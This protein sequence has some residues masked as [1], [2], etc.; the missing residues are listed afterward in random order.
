MLT[1]EFLKVHPLDSARILENL[2]ISDITS[3]L[4]LAPSEIAA[5]VISLMDSVKA[6]E[7]L[8]CMD[9]QKIS[10]II[11]NLPNEVAAV[12]LRRMKNEFRRAVF[13]RLPPITVRTLQ[14]L[15]RYP[16]GTAG[17]LMDPKFLELPEDITVNKA[18]KRIRKHPHLASDYLYV[19]SRN[20]RLRGVVSIREF[21]VLDHKDLLAGVMCTNVPRIRGYADNQTILS[22]DGWLEYHVLPVVNDTDVLLGIIRYDKLRRLEI[23]SA[24]GYDVAQTTVTGVAL[25][26]LYGIGLSGLVKGVISAFDSK[27]GESY[28]K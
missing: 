4:E 9:P 25:G 7:S 22:H 5:P 12:Y 16:D 21:L 15:L 17:A 8:E 10:A 1:F 24:R 26:E 11:A 13:D 3:Y 14:T 18:L 19:V 6:I 20:H 27:G 23:E 28:G 2:Q